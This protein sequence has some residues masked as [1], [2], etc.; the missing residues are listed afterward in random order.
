MKKYIVEKEVCQERVVHK[1]YPFFYLA[2]KWP[3]N[4]EWRETCIP[5]ST[6]GIVYSKKKESLKKQCRT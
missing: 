5:L 6:F 1:V 3:T 2:S 4:S